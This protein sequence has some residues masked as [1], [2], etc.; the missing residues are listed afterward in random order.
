MPTPSIIYPWQLRRKS[1]ADGQSNAHM[2]PYYN[3]KAPRII[4][5]PCLCRHVGALEARNRGLVPVVI[6]L[7]RLTEFRRKLEPEGMNSP[8]CRGC[9]VK[10]DFTL[11]TPLP[12]T[13]TKRS[14]WSTIVWFRVEFRAEHH[15]FRP[16][17][18]DPHW[19]GSCTRILRLD[20][21][22]GTKC[23]YLALCL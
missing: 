21:R 17:R 12:L 14:L 15:K 20:L 3:L 4:P 23:H 1:F 2:P 9:D 16:S 18:Q 19:E 11:G 13:F 7:V 6:C 8:W 22:C 10:R 5:R